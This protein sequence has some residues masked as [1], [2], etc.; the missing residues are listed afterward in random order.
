MLSGEWQEKWGGTSSEGQQGNDALQWVLR[1][2]QLLIETAGHLSGTVFWFVC[3]YVCVYLQYMCM[4]VR[5]S[6][7]VWVWV[8]MWVWEY[9]D[10]YVC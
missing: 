6:V 3:V 10:V 5:V 9:V 8:C 4:C 2:I 1:N 7:G